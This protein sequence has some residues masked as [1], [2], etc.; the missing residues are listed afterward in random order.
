M[1]IRIVKVT[2]NIW[3]LRVWALSKVEQIDSLGTDALQDIG[4][5]KL[6]LLIQWSIIGEH[7]IVINQ[8]FLYLNIFSKRNKICYY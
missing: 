7:I 2:N 1:I 8:M 3:G 4:Q 5:G 6:F